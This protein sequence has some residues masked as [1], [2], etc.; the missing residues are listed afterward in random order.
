M[1]PQVDIAVTLVDTG[2]GLPVVTEGDGSV[3]LGA[4]GLVGVSPG[5]LF[6][7]EGAVENVATWP[8][9]NSNFESLVGTIV[10]Y[11]LES[12]LNSEAVSGQPPAYTEQAALHTD[13][14][15]IL[16]LDTTNIF[17]TGVINGK[18]QAWPGPVDYS[19]VG[20]VALVIANQSVSMSF[21]ALKAIAFDDTTYGWCLSATANLGTTLPPGPYILMIRPD[22]STS[23][24]LPDNI[25]LTFGVFG[26][27]S[28]LYKG[29]NYQADY[30]ALPTVTTYA[31]VYDFA[32]GETP[33]VLGTGDVSAN[34]AN[35]LGAPPGTTPFMTAAGMFGIDSQSG[36]NTGC[37][38]C[39]LDCSAFGAVAFV[40]P[41]ASI[42][43]SSSPGVWNNFNSALNYSTYPQTDALGNWWWVRLP[44]CD[45]SGNL[46]LEPLTSE[47]YKSGSAPSPGCP[48]AWLSINEPG[49]LSPVTPNVWTDQSHRLHTSES[50]AFSWIARQRGTATVPLIIAG[51]DDY[52]PTIGSQVCLWDI[53][54]DADFEVFSGTIDDYEVKWLGVNGDRIVT[55]TCVSLDQVFDTIRLPPLLFE[56]QTAGFIFTALFAYASGSPVTLGTV[57]AGPSIANY[58]TENFSSISEEMTRLSTLAE[59]VWGVDPGTGTAYFTPPN[60]T[61]SP[62]TLDAED[63]LWEQFTLKEERHDYRNRQIL[64]VPD[65]LAVQSSEYFVGTG[66]KTFA[67]LRPV[68]SITAAWV[69]ENIQNAATGTF[70]G[71]PNPG[72]TI[73]FTYASGGGGGYTWV[74]NNEYFVGAAIV[75][76]N[77]NIQRATVAGAG[78]QSGPTIPSFLTNFGDV[79]TD[80]TMTWTNQGPA[81][82][83][84]G[85]NFGFTY[86]FVASLLTGSGATSGNAQFGLVLIGAT[87]ANTAQNLAD[88]INAIQTLA[89]VTFS[90]ATW[91]N[92][93]VNADEPAGSSTIVV[94]NKPAGAAFVAGLAWTGTAFS[95]DKAVTHGGVT[96]FGTSTVNVGVQGQTTGGSTFTIV[97][98]PG[99]NIVTSATPLGPGGAAPNLQIQ[100]MAVDADYVQVE[101]TVAVNVR[102]AIEAGTGKYQQVSSDDQAQTLPSALQLAQQQLAAFGVIPQTFEFTT[103]SA[104]LYVGQVLAISL[105]SPNNA[106]ALINASWFIQEIRAEV[107]PVYGEDGA[108]DR[109]LPGGGHFRYTVTCIDVAQIGSW[110]DFWLGLSGGSGDGGGST[111][112]GGGTLGSNPSANNSYSAAITAVAGTPLAV[113][114]GLN[115]AAVMVAVYDGAGNLMTIPSLQVTSANVVTVTFGI[116]FTGTIVVIGV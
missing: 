13:A 61:P 5:A 87:E 85:G 108:S 71:Q 90:L 42:G 76:P 51:D 31:I 16:I 39:A 27:C 59:F 35:A 36:N 69:T 24:W 78:T 25:N 12:T 14:G 104:G 21:L 34:A 8:S 102:A 43:P 2:Y 45:G 110:L 47:V 65:A 74:A 22:L 48:V 89:G 10:N 93:I 33:T 86:S 91:E 103:M 92:P 30:S 82:F 101:D 72:D 19:Q 115:T 3:T 28:W 26:T 57:D 70:T 80:F 106:P 77:G 58:K 73:T 49:S 99:S 23:G 113:T 60:T 32:T 20:Q 105:S 94:R 44:L 29:V 64:K 79:T 84:P 97:Y 96:T 4:F 111:A 37:W 109:W 112:V 56:D 7:G 40:M 67:L 38:Y 107:V 81:G 11:D 50:I 98:T 88:A 63:V 62:F 15:L 66:Q 17:A 6:L 53:T 54:E 1:I 68:E 95:F 114:H 75:D 46:V 55:M 41:D 100:Y 52:M 83:G 18:T 9:Y 116:G